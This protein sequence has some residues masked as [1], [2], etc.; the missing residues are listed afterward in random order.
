VRRAILVVV[1]AAV[2]V[3]ADDVYLRGGGQITGE[4]VEQT[5]SSVSVN[6]GGGTLSVQASS[7]LRIEKNASPVREFRTRA[8]KIPAG[9]AEA[10]RGLGRWA[11][12]EGLATLS[13]QAYAKV[14]AILPNDAEA[15]TA[16][17]RIKL[18][19][20]W[21][22]EEEGYRALG[23]VELDGEWMTPTEQKAILAERQASEETLRLQ[24]AARIL[25]EE[26]ADKQRKNREAADREAFLRGGLQTVGQEVLGYGPATWPAQPLQLVP[27]DSSAMPPAGGQR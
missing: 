21:V 24:D 11:A 4:I 12:D 7:V 22:T 15:N 2:P 27:S 19:G 25:A 5:A 6:V 8:A 9:D 17:G 16:L 26:K 10:W 18:N 1:L 14:V 23:Y 13:G 20:K 3:L